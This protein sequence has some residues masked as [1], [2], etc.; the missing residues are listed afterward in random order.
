MILPNTSQLVMLLLNVYFNL[1]ML[2]PCLNKVEIL[3]VQTFSSEVLGFHTQVQNSPDAK[4]DLLMQDYVKSLI[5][6]SSIK[7]EALAIAH[8]LSTKN[9]FLQR[10]KQIQ[11]ELKAFLACLPAKQ[12]M[13]YKDKLLIKPY[14]K[15]INELTIKYSSIHNLHQNTQLQKSFDSMNEFINVIY[16]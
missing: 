10:A 13:V 5:Q 6:L 7:D 14:F 11:P 1:A 4:I 15:T 12:A 3:N 9:S 2:N 8:M 16:N